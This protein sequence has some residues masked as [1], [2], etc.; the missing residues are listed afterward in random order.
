MFVNGSLVDTITG[1][2]FG[3]TYSNIFTI[4]AGSST[5]EFFN[6]AISNVRIYNRAIT[7]SEIQDLYNE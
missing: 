1:Y 5:T 6:G 2:N 7:S 3:T 4:G